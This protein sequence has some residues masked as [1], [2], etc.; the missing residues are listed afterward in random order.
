MRKLHIVDSLLVAV[1]ITALATSGCA[2]S[3][4]PGGESADRPAPG[5]DR[6]GVRYPADVLDLKNWYLTLPTGEKGDPDTV[7]QPEL[8]T[9][10]GRDFRP[11]D[12]KDGVVFVAN[13]GGATTE[14]SD[15]PRSELREMIGSEKASWS[16]TAGTHT[17]SVRQAVTALPPAKPEVTTAQ[18]HDASSDALAIR[19]EATNL[20]AQYDDGKHDGGKT[21][22]TLDP[23]YQLGTPY[24][25]R[26][27]AAN[28]RIEVFYNGTKKADIPKSGSE[29]YFKSGSYLQSNP[30]KGDAPDATGEVVLFSLQVTHSA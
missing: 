15:Y 21:D 22:I 25:L 19:L 28:S 4:S 6:S 18:I 2:S 11:N 14:N 20:I 10:S 1:V 27:V 5:Q 26:I 17:L 9:Y 7:H 29:W 16:N 13:A 3:A 12:A 8:S 30:T 24:D 23:A